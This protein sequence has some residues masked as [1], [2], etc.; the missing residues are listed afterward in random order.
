[1]LYPLIVEKDHTSLWVFC[2]TVVANISSVEAE[3]FLW[4]SS[5]TYYN[6]LL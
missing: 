4:N 2:T 6:F 3:S 1:M 5:N